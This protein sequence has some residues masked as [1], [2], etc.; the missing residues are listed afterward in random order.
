MDY[1]NKLLKASRE[2]VAGNLQH[3]V[4][5]VDPKGEVGLAGSLNL[6]QGL[7]SEDNLNSTIA[8]NLKNNF[9]P[10]GNIEFCSTLA[11]PLLPCS[12]SSRKWKGSTMIQ[13]IASKTLTAS[14]YVNSG[15]KLL[16]LISYKKPCFFLVCM[17]NFGSHYDFSN[18]LDKSV[19]EDQIM[20]V[21]SF[22]EI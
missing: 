3:I 18:I 1:K 19:T 10:K 11:F 21:G 2:A 4:M 14:G 20:T 12:P 5:T 16:M 22:W 6:I 8:R 7:F 15:R 9:S 17:Y 13:K